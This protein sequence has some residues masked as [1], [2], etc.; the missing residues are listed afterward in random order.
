[1]EM[2]EEED[3]REENCLDESDDKK[4]FFPFNG[5]SIR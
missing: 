5:Q 4:A 1:M 2:E 3:V